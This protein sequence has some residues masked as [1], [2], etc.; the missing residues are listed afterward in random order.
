VPAGDSDKRIHTRKDRLRALHRRF[1]GKSALLARELEMMHVNVGSPRDP[2]VDAHLQE[3]NGVKHMR[4]TIIGASVLAALTLTAVTAHASCTDPRAAQLNPVQNVA[5]L[6]LHQGLSPSWGRDADRIVGTWHVTYTADGATSPYA[7]AFIQ[8]HSDRTE[9]ENI[10]MPVLGGNICMGSWK[11]VDQWHVFRNHVGWLFN[12]GII[13]GYFNETETDEVAPDGD[14][15]R[16]TNDTIGYDL[17]GNLEFEVKGTAS[18]KRI[19]P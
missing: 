12:N 4:K 14:S 1:V 8:W 16:G 11:T 17:S 19:A 15:Y 13:A 7:Q 2:T 6:I 18:A 3:H 9:W 5:P 10:T